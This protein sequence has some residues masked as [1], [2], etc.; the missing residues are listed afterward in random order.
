[1]NLSSVT[2]LRQMV[3]QN[4]NQKTSVNSRSFTDSLQEVKDANISKVDAYK[5]HLKSKFGEITVMSVGSDQ[6]SMDKLGAGT[7]GY[8][9]VVIA[10]NIL[11]QMANNPEK[12]AYY[13]EKI[14]DHFDSIPETE[15]FMASIGHV[16]TSCGVV[17][18]EDGKVTYYLS[19]EESPEKKAKFEAAQK[20]KREEKAIKR[21]ENLER[22]KE[23]YEKRKNLLELQ[24]RDELIDK[25]R[26]GKTVDNMVDF[27]IVRGN[28]TVK[29]V[30]AVYEQ[31]ISVLSSNII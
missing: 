9:N 27:R 18:H 25:M 19:G 17:I 2:N 11:E 21:K 26:N 24:Y 13:E 5:E 22:S 3:Y 1:M 16:T 30:I 14:Q 4:A 12:A 10:P 31:A 20:E 15:A 7:S 28:S 23:A 8:G 29:P 6:S